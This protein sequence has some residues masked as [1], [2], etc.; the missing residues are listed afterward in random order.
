MS[1][2]RNQV[3]VVGVEGGK[4]TLSKKDKKSAE[5]IDRAVGGKGAVKVHKTLIDTKSLSYIVDRDWE[6]LCA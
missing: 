1:N 2:L 5:V 4:P 6:T 3:V